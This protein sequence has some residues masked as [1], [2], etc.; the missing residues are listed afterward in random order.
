MV[1]GLITKSGNRRELVYNF[2][3]RYKAENNGDSPTI[4]EIAQGV[5]IGSTSVHHHMNILVGMKI[6]RRKPFRS[7]SIEVLSGYMEQ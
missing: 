2:I 1:R 5:G 3:V 6:I 4:R 7:R